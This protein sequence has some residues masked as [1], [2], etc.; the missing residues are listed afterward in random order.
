MPTTRAE[1]RSRL[2]SFRF[3][4]VYQL[5]AATVSRAPRSGW[6]TDQPETAFGYGFLSAGFAG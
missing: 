1:T 4:R 5:G 2:R 6:D 3:S